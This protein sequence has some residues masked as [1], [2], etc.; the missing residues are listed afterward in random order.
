M[1]TV[2]VIEMGTVVD[3]IQAGMGAKV[4]K[5]LGID[6]SYPNRVALVMNVPSKR[7]GKKDIVKIEGKII[8]EGSVNTIALISPG[9]SINIIKNSKV[10]KKFEVQLPDKL[11]GIGKCPNPN[12]MTNSESDVS[13]AFTKEDSGYRCHFCERL[14]RA[15]ELV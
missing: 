13:K 4:L 7:M 12:C 2:D 11:S 9:A 5:I 15:E 1:L 14:F 6:E 3:H 10:E 8:S